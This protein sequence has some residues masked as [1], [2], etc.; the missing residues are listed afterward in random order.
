MTNA[1]WGRPA[2]PRGRNTMTTTALMRPTPGG[3]PLEQLP[4]HGHLLRRHG[5]PGARHP[6][7]RRVRPAGAGCTSSG[8]AGGASIP[9]DELAQ[10]EGEARVQRQNRN[11][12][13]P[14]DAARRSE[15]AAESRDGRCMSAI[16]DLGQQS[17]RRLGAPRSS[18]RPG[19]ITIRGP[20]GDHC[21]P[22]LVCGGRYGRHRPRPEQRAAGFADPLRRAGLFDG[23]HGFLWQD[24]AAFPRILGFL[25]GNAN[26]RQ[27]GRA[28]R[29]GGQRDHDDEP[30]EVMT[31]DSDQHSA[32][33]GARR[34]LRRVKDLHLRE[35]LTD[36][37]GR[38][39]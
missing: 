38:C 29:G 36:P 5:G 14:L 16:C 11:D 37:N 8:G 10:L 39:D 33:A 1:G 17:P 19:A 26:G 22:T 7:P 21:C 2:S 18:S 24:P 28:Q 25:E 12:G 15:R 23:G 4:R 3:A 35:L 13:H 30:G 32:M 27:R 9:F 20:V 34:A 31:I 6:T